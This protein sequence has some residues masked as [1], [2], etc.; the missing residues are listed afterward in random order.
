MR[1]F[2]AVSFVLLL[3]IIASCSPKADKSK[4]T[5]A[6]GLIPEPA[7]VKISG[8]SFILNDATEISD[9][10]GKEEIIQLASYLAGEI[11]K[12]HQLKLKTYTSLPA[13]QKN[14]VLFEL[15]STLENKEG[16]SLVVNP[17]RVILKAKNTQGLFYATQTLLQLISPQ[18]GSS[19]EISI[20]GVEIE[21]APLYAWRGMH[22]DIS[23]HFFPVEFVKKMIDA[24]AMHKLNTFHWHLTDDQGWRIEIKKYPKLTEIGGWRDKTVAGHMADHPYRYDEAKYGG[25]YT[26]EQI[27]DVVA[28]AKAK[29]ITVVPEI[30]MPGHAVAALSAYPE[31][32]CAGGPFNVY[33]LWGVSDDV[34]CAGKERT[35]QFLEDILSE[36][37]DLFPGQYI[38]VGGDECP[39]IRWKKCADCQKRIK[40]EGLK[41]EEELQGYFTRRI[42]KFLAAK[43]K[44]LIGWDEILDGGGLP[45]RATVMSWRGTKGGITA[46][47]SG[48]DVVMT[49]AA[50]C[51]FD[52]YQDLPEYEPISIGGYKTLEKVYSYNLLP[53]ELTKEESKHILGAQANLWTEYITS[54]K[55]FEYM[56]FPRL[57][58][59]SE[60]LWTPAGK[61]NYEQFLSRMDKHY[62][63][64]DS[65]GINYKVAMP[66][67]F[68]ADNKFLEE[69]T[70][71]TLHCAIPSAE[72]RYTLD[73]SEPVKGSALYDSA[74]V[75]EL[76]AVKTLKAK[77]F[78]PNGKTSATRTGKFEHTSLLNDTVLSNPAKGISYNYYNREFSSAK[79]ISG[80]PAS[81]GSMDTICVP[82]SISNKEWFGMVYTGFIKIP[83]DDI[84]TFL[85]KSDDGAMLSVD[86]KMIIDNDGYHYG[87]EKAGQL[88]LKKGFHRIQVS[89]FQ[90]K[91]GTELDVKIKSKDIEEKEIPAEM[92]WH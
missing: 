39:K 52:H 89:Y 78:L 91:F 33:P 6:P 35:F 81:T 83:A 38:H 46:A 87:N 32:S 73:G 80:A 36:V 85:L 48:H 61:Q 42:E 50:F 31:Y 27:R 44:K 12:A 30:E 43:G 64:L 75:L 57:C 74:F 26:Q 22:M 72:I 67:G 90:G 58:A 86:N 8:E 56:V 54:E 11:E 23:R 55:H 34:Y 51:Y 4:S 77:A 10:E 1:I 69:K 71:V 66:E 82:D 88:A 28:Y 5:D 68:D 15:D 24:M 17:D 92:L 14:A 25:F 84:Y 40:T 7:S 62:P 2:N 13:D 53:A 18:Q 16:Y 20:P 3:G 19:R 49:P 63:R 70:S 60:I 76:D 47:R 9:Q 59:L 29:Y 79:N 65:K 45:E 21:D 41:N 37:A